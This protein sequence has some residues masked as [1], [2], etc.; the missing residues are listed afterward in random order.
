MKFILLAAGPTLGGPYMFPP[1]SK[2]KCLFH[3]N[4]EVILEHTVRALKKCGE[5]DIR[6]VTGYKSKMIERFNEE[7]KL[8]LTL[9]Y[10]PDWV[11]DNKGS[12]WKECHKSIRIGLEGINEDII[13]GTGDTWLTERGITQFLASKERL[14]IGWGGH[15]PQTFGVGKEYLSLLRQAKGPGCGRLL[16]YFCMAQKG[17][18]GFYHEQNVYFG[19]SGHR[20]NH[21]AF[22]LA[23][24]GIR[25][26]DWYWQTDEGKKAGVKR[27]PPKRKKA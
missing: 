1:N 9:I 6:L 24:D 23:L 21:L 2:P 22:H 27:K 17:I 18:T 15:G 25:D 12:R 4:G 11:L 10:N 3:Y 5:T 19:L 8:G 13:I 14:T 7:Q 20:E 26:I 16:Y